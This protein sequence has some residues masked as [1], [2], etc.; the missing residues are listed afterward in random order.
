MDAK[1]AKKL[2]EL[3][4]RINYP[5]SIKVHATTSEVIG[6]SDDERKAVRD[7]IN[8]A[9]AAI[10]PFA[11]EAEI[12][13][14][15]AERR[16]CS[17]AEARKFFMDGNDR[18]GAAAIAASMIA[19]ILVDVLKLHNDAAEARYEAYRLACE[20]GVAVAPTCAS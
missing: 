8:A 14:A 4:N 19:Q 1:V 7:E 18:K 5:I 2:N 13:A 15:A 11:V 16:E 6:G 20:Q 9:F 17:F 10:Y 3:L 12:R